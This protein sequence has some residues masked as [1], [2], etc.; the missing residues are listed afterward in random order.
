[1]A[2][3]QAISKWRRGRAP[4]GAGGGIQGRKK[5]SMWMERGDSDEL[6]EEERVG[7]QR[8]WAAVAMGTMHADVFV[9]E[10]EEKSTVASPLRCVVNAWSMSIYI[11]THDGH[12]SYLLKA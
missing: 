2:A 3:R 10:W 6:W 12:R 8:L 11:S 5:E 7:I 9:H 1:M 4:G